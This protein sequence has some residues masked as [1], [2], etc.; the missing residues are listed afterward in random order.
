MCCTDAFLLMCNLSCCRMVMFE[1]SLLVNLKMLD[2][3]QLSRQISIE[4]L[5]NNLAQ[6]ASKA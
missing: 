6:T 3:L 4:S 1:Y 2:D 5:H